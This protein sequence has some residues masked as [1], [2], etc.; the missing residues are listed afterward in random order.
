[1]QILKFW[2]ALD[3]LSDA[4]A[5]CH[6]W[7]NSL[8][9]EIRAVGR[10]LKPTGNLATSIDCP[11]PGGEG[12]PRRVVCHADGSARAFCGD[13][14][15]MCT[16]LDLAKDDIK[17]H[18]LDRRA[19]GSALAAA[20]ALTRPSRTL[21]MTPVLR[22]GTR[23]IYA[24]SGVPVFLAIPG[25]RPIL[26]HTDFKEVLSLTPP[27]VMLVPGPMSLPEDIA[28]L[29]DQHGVRTLALDDLVVA[30]G[31][32]KLA[33]T[34]Q[35]TALM[36]R[37]EQQLEDSSAASAA[38]KRAWN[39]PPDARW[40]EITIRFISEEVINV[41]FRGDTR[42]F[43]PDGLGMKNATN[44]K[45]KAAWTY[46]RAFA[47]A[48]GRLPVH[49]ANVRETAKHQKQKQALSKALKAA[50]GITG[51]PIPTDGTDYVTRFVPSADDLNQGKQGQH[52][53]NFVGDA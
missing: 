17:I 36:D 43:E 3:A 19:L 20:L 9:G 26:R 13:R 22:I 18:E 53:R 46:L 23:D 38:P 52:Q 2:T 47:I 48:R 35:G 4:G 8:G 29:L 28:A 7:V 12:C 31:P 30:T 15:K 51:D 39:L 16:D 40:E 1:M 45:P 24:G 21:P 50:F 5:S 49:H 44:G 14:P 33:L 10:F 27:V 6:Y 41:T 34:A 37:L 42:R 25:A 11:S 32:G